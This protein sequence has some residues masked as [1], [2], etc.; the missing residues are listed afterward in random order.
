[1]GKERIHWIDVLKGIGILLV[2]MGHTFKDS[3]VYFWIYSFHMPLFFLISG[4]LIEPRQEVGTYKVFVFKKCRSLLLPFLFFRVLLYLYWVLVESHFRDL[5]LGP[6]WFLIVLFFD[7]IFITPILLNFRK[8]VHSVFCMLLCG[9]LFYVVQKHLLTFFSFS[10]FALYLLNWIMRIFNA[11]IWFAGGFFLHK[12][13]RLLPKNRYFI[14]TMFFIC[15]IISLSLFDKNH[16]VSL[17]S[18]VVGNWCY[19][20]VLAF[21]GIGYSFIV[22]KYLIKK[23]KIIEWVG[24]YTIVILAIH[25]PIKRIVLFIFSL[26]TSIDI[27]VL[28]HNILSAFLLSLL[29]LVLCI[30]VI[31]IFRWL[32]IHTGKFG[33][34]LLSF[35]R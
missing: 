7:E 6:I 19:Y 30:P 4:F 31:L 16:E 29:V 22:S 10:G 23:C 11:G 27:Y 25:E 15:I 8:I 24:A 12:L 33:Q 32:K 3:P 21:S 20:I 28:Q 26:I 13:I 17:Y 5:D 9:G 34:N 1:M 18:N 35:V 2:I 14:F